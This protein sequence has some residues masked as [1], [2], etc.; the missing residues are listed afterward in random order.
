MAEAHRPEDERRGGPESAGRTV[1]LLVAAAIVA[2][3][4]V[5]LV[6]T[7]GV[8]RPPELDAVGA[9]DR[10]ERSLALFGWRDEG[11]CLDIVAPDGSLRTV[12]CGMQEY[13]P[14]LLWDERG[15][16]LVRYG[17]AGEQI[18]IIDVATGLVVVRE[19]LVRDAQDERAPFGLLASTEREAGQLVVRDPEGRVVWR[20][21]AP[22][23]YRINGS[24]LDA[25]TGR[26]AL[27][28]SARRLL[29][30]APGEPE[31][32]VW[33]AD[34]R[35]SYAELLWEGTDRRSE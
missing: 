32:R 31:P 33:V 8:A 9:D 11:S 2:V 27:L 34:V 21:D 4:T 28:D 7:I 13:G 5:V 10:P 3:L 30:L 6:V 29:V 17:P 15:I 1:G 25:A 23:P 18:V 22:E 12:R 35:L 20:V 24:A 14:P 19:P 26:L 16:G